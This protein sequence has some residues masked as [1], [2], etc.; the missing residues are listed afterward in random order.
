MSN[1]P[2]AVVDPSSGEEV[3]TFPFATDDDVDQA[4]AQAHAAH[5]DWAGLTIEQR[6]EVVKRVAELFEERKHDLSEIARTE[7]GKALDQGID[8]TELCRDIFAYF[9]E[10]G[11]ALAADQ[12]IPT[13]D[14]AKAFVRRRSIGVLLGIMPWNFPFYQVARF[15]APNLILGNTIVLK[16]A[17]SVPRSALAVE[18][19]LHDAGVPREVY[20]NLFATHDQVATIIADP[21]VQGVSLTGSER[22]GSAVAA[23][24]GQH[25]KKCVLELGGSDPMIVLDT[26]DLDSLVGDAW[27]FRVYNAGQACNANKRMIVRSEV[28]GDFVDA[29]VERA[30]SVEDFAPLSSRAAAETLHAQV[31]EAVAAGATLHVGGELADDAS[32]RYSPAVLTGV[33]P[34]MRAYR[35]ELFGP[36][37]VVYEVTSDDEAVSLANDTPYGLGGSVFSTDVDRA[38]AVADRL[39]VGMANV[40]TVAGEAAELPFGGV[41]RSGFG[42]ELGPLGMDE[43]VNKQLLYV[44]E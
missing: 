23:L 42:R 24:A 44:A 19:L 30:R 2:Y 5:A 6:G 7:M 20:T 26:D 21:R 22:A 35:E 4:V 28:F 29:L 40:N 3:E 37:A 43:F 31:Q 18:Q 32:A 27:D 8:E 38:R 33:T 34:D 12:P 39:E 1:P 17:E 14:S 9:A 15:V 13:G 41:K 11:P 36:V 10:H 25:L 16:H